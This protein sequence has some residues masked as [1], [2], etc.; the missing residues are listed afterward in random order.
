[1]EIPNGIY[2]LSD[3]CFFEGFATALLLITINWGALGGM[4]PFAVAFNVFSIAAFLSP[5]CGCHFNPAVTVAVAV[6]ES[7]RNGKYIMKSSFH[8]MLS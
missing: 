6:K 2:F 3:I 4:Q 1:M 8:L 5:V 7:S